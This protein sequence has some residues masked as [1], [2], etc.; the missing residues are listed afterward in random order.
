MKKK[1]EGKRKRTLKK[2][3]GGGRSEDFL[4]F[5]FSKFL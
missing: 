1:G 5:S 3:M 4:S 2:V